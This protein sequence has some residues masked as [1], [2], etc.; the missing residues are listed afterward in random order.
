MPRNEQPPAHLSAEAA[1]EW[2]RLRNLL[3]S[4]RCW[5]GEGKGLVEAYCVAYGRFVKAELKLQENDEVIKLPG[6]KTPTHNPWLA[7]TER[8]QNQMRQIAAALQLDR[9]PENENAAL[10][11]EGRP[12]PM[13]DYFRTAPP[14]ARRGRSH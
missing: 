6:S 7:V 3:E 4:R 2:H 14:A 13:S 11:D 5:D 12:R 10:P 8:A 1:V 9:Q